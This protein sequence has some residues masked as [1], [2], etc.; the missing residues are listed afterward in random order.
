MCDKQFVFFSYF[1]LSIIFRKIK[2]IHFRSKVAGGEHGFPES[3][4]NSSPTFCKIMNF[5]LKNQNDD[6]ITSIYEC[7]KM[8][9]IK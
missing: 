7:S 6:V 9:K 5:W 2:W 1:F 4:K 3:M 8:N